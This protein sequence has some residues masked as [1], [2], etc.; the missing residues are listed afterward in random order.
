VRV[1]R[2]VLFLRA[3]VPPSREVVGWLVTLI[4]QHRRDLI[5]AS[6]ARVH[7]HRLVEAVGVGGR[8]GAVDQL[9]LDSL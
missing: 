7:L 1:A 4:S 8:I 9:N 5:E 3:P 6:D 2:P